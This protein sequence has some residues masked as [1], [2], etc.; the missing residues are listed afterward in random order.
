MAP[1]MSLERAWEGVLRGF[2]RVELARPVIM[3]REYP[4]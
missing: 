2:K 4:I 3:K 1:T